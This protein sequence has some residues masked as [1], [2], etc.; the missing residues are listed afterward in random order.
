MVSGRSQGRRSGQRRVGERNAVEQTAPGPAERGQPNQSDS[1][2]GGQRRRQ[3]QA[4]EFRR[5]MGVGETELS[6]VEGEIWQHGV[7][8]EIWRLRR[9]D[10]IYL[11]HAFLVGSTLFRF[12]ARVAPLRL[13]LGFVWRCRSGGSKAGVQPIESEP[14]RQRYWPGATRHR[15]PT[16]TPSAAA[17]S[18]NYSLIILEDGRPWSSFLLLYEITRCTLHMAYMSLHPRVAVTAARCCACQSAAVTHRLRL[19]LRAQT[20][21]GACLSQR[22]GNV[23]FI[24]ARAGLV[25]ADRVSV[26]LYSLQNLHLF[27]GLNMTST[28]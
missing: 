12:W 13:R 19:G 10:G 6:G 28:W 9:P 17:L 20:L 1:R 2:E 5:T 21:G 24:C 4:H 26:A 15:R 22:V 7:V 3:Q 18:D 16:T 8:R 23:R 11:G 27:L 14:H 25:G